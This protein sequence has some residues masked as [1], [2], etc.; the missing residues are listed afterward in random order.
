MHENKENYYK[1]LRVSNVWSNNYIEYKTNSD[2]NKTI[3]VQEY[4]NKI[5][6]Y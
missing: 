2:R 1:P 3:S 4:L 6:S 5:G